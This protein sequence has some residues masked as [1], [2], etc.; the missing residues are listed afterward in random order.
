MAKGETQLYVFVFDGQ[1]SSSVGGHALFSLPR[2]HRADGRQSRPSPS[3]APFASLWDAWLTTV[4]GWNDSK[5]PA[6]GHQVGVTS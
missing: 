4:P 2:Q 3:R 1:L 6:L 5:Q